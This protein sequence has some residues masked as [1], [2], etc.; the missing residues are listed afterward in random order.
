MLEDQRQEAALLV[1]GTLLAD[2][3]TRVQTRLF[4]EFCK[5]EDGNA[6]HIRAKMNALSYVIGEIRSL[7]A[8]AIDNKEQLSDGN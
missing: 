2:I 5:Q 6:H 7:A 1:S 8:R 4:E 3:E